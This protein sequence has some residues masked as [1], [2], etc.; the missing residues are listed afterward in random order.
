MQ[1][2]V[3]TVTALLRPGLL[4]HIRPLCAAHLSKMGQPRHGTRSFELLTTVEALW[5]ANHTKRSIRHTCRNQR[6]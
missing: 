2:S 5:F 6:H 3:P 1:E 4:L